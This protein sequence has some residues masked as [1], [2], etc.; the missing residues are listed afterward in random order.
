MK[1]TF[2]IAGFVCI[3]TLSGCDKT[4]DSNMEKNNIS[5]QTQEI[6]IEDT[7]EEPD[8][9]PPEIVCSV[10]AIGCV[11]GEKNDL[12]TGITVTDDS[13]DENVS[14]EVDDSKVDMDTVGEYNVTFTAKDKAGNQS[15]LD[16]PCFVVMKSSPS[17]VM[18][19][20]SK[21]ILD[22]ENITSA[23]SCSGWDIKDKDPGA[24]SQSYYPFQSKITSDKFYYEIFVN[25]EKDILDT[26]NGTYAGINKMITAEVILTNTNYGHMYLD[27][28]WMPELVITSFM[29]SYY[30]YEVPKWDKVCFKSN[31]GVIVFDE[32]H[33]FGA[34]NS[35]YFDGYT[36]TRLLEFCFNSMDEINLFTEIINENDAYAEFISGEESLW[37][38][39]LTDDNKE[40]INKV[41]EIYRTLSESDIARN[42]PISE[43]IS[44]IK[45]VNYQNTATASNAIADNSSNKVFPGES[46]T[47]KFKDGGITLLDNDNATVKLVSMEQDIFDVKVTFSVKNNRDTYFIFNLEDLYLGDDGADHIMLDGNKGPAPG[48]TRSYSYNIDHQDDSIVY[49][50]ELSELNGTI[51]LSIESPDESYIESHDISQFSLSDHKNEIEQ[52]LSEYI[53]YN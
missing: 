31:K 37:G 32:D 29:F 15:S 35:D 39:N 48:K 38:T 53:K 34:G 22:D 26:T 8:V 40:H 1:K 42:I 5:Q 43:N 47:V 52:T 21:T 7:T 44:D 25:D 19:Y 9:T 20:I 6:T 45:Y 51:S 11:I 13:G 18:D 46:V 4:S 17:E 50:S 41:I 2:L 33:V 10:D 14:V 12:L 36:S 27:T 30:G 28:P 24:S 3:I 23:T 16:I 49:L